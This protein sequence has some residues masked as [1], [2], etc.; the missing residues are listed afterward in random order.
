MVE[1][2]PGEF[3]YRAQLEKHPD[4]HCYEPVVELP[5]RRRRGYRERH[6]QV[7]DDVG[8]SAAAFEAAKVAVG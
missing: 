8:M 3:H 1:G 4:C 7:D 2:L 5:H 6:G